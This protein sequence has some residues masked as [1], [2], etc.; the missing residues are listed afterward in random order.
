MLICEGRSRVNSKC[1]DFR[2]RDLQPDATN[3]LWKFGGLGT[4]GRLYMKLSL[5]EEWVS[6]R[7]QIGGTE[8]DTV[9]TVVQSQIEWMVQWYRD[10]D[11]TMMDTIINTVVA[12]IIQSQ[13]QWWIQ[14]WIQWCR[15]RYSV[16]YSDTEANT[17]MDTVIQRQKQW[18]ILGRSKTYRFRASQSQRRWFPKQ[19]I[20]EGDRGRET[21]K[22][23]FTVYL[24]NATEFKYIILIQDLSFNYAHLTVTEA[25]IETMSLLR[26]REIDE[27]SL[28]GYG[29]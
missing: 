23:E 29:E 24:S 1:N 8:A 27:E 17:M 26:R 12:T 11:D 15:V 7:P 4:M 9:D 22:K 18:W 10:S 16:G 21:E 14:C 20:W 28:K 3:L 5:D 2:N 25:T 13:T 6:G 19:I